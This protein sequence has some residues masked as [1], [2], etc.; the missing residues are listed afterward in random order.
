MANI[1][2]V[3]SFSLGDQ[4]LADA[5]FLLDAVLDR[6]LGPAIPTRIRTRHSDAISGDVSLIQSAGYSTSAYCFELSVNNK[7]AL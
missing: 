5:A 7:C 2:C 3:L 6:P 1:R 4:A